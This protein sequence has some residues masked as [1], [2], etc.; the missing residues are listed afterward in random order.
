MEW[1]SFLEGASI[2][3]TGLHG[4]QINNKENKGKSFETEWEERLLNKMC[5]VAI[6][7][8]KEKYPSYLL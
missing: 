5:D 8:G 1:T 4:C 6:K 3:V 2:V 7:I